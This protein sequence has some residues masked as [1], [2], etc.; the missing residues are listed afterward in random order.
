MV[1]DGITE[2]VNARDEEFGLTRLEE[3]LIQNANRPLP[4]IGD[5]IMG[6]VKQHGVQQDDQSL[7]LV[8]VR[9]MAAPGE[10]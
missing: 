7:L 5:S 4:E 3:V 10:C 8:R 6:E 9:D 1:T 2:V